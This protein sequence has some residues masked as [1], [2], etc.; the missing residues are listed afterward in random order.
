MSKLL[1]RTGEEIKEGVGFSQENQA[2]TGSA[3]AG[4]ASVRTGLVLVP[5]ARILDNPY[6][7]RSGY[8]PAKTVGLALD[9][10]SLKEDLRATL[11]LQQV[12][13]A[14]IGRLDANSGEFTPAPKLLYNDAAS[15]RRMPR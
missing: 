12:P 3:S 8:D 6:Q 11:G 10:R 2:S 4:S 1:Q 15:V 5:I 13:L 9:I 14:R 7:T